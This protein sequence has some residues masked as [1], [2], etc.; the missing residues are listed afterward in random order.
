MFVL[1]IQLGCPRC[2]PRRH[3]S[4]KG[5]GVAI[6][7]VAMF[8]QQFV[9]S[10]AVD[11]SVMVTDISQ[12]DISARALSVMSSALVASRSASRNRS[13]NRS[14]AS[15]RGVSAPGSAAAASAGGSALL[16]GQGG[17]SASRA[18]SRM[19]PTRWKRQ[20]VDADTDTPCNLLMA[21]SEDLS[22]PVL[23]IRCMLNVPIAVV[24]TG[25]GLKGTS[26]GVRSCSRISHG[27]CL[28]CPSCEWS[29]WQPV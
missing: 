22:A 10:G 23:S 3:V 26:V 12:S 13:R 15:P 24:C 16:S 5:Q 4:P 20:R 27:I 2:V 14:R 8:Q 11:G 21:P 17:P 29:W 19:R 6:S 25:D 1:D 9:V 18:G 7:A 28:S